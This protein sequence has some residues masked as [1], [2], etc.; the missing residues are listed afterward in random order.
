MVVNPATTRRVAERVDVV[1]HRNR[2]FVRT[3]RNL[4]RNGQ[5][6]KEIDHLAARQGDVTFERHFANGKGDAG[7]SNRPRRLTL[8]S[9]TV[10]TSAVVS[11]PGALSAT[12]Q[13]LFALLNDGRS[14][15]RWILRTP[16]DAIEKGGVLRRTRRV[17]SHL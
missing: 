13:N 2:R 17:A 5:Y 12:D 14:R 9:D 1:I 4:A 6:F 8:Y 11:T 15:R 16:R 3:G 10:V 7:H